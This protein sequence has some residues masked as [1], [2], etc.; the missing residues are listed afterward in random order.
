[1]ECAIAVSYEENGGGPAE[2]GDQS[3]VS[4]HLKG[5]VLRASVVSVEES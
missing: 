5:L 3:L 1:M 4:N 2:I